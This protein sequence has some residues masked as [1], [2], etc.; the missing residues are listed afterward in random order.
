M[1]V[2]RR[3]VLR[4]EMCSFLSLAMADMVVLFLRFVVFC[5]YQVFESVAHG[6]EA[7]GEDEVVVVLIY[8][9]PLI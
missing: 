7:D 6:A 4:G 8:G 5:E 3:F 2:A 1:S 9:V